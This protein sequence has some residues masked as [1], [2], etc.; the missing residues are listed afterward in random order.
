[1]SCIEQLLGRDSH[2]LCLWY[3]AY[4]ATQ[5]DMARSQ[6]QNIGNARI[7]ASIDFNSEK[8][9]PIS[10]DIGSGNSTLYT[11]HGCIHDRLD[12]Y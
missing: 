4:P 9:F 1:M 6:P 7:D 11:F 2:Y 8:L 12:L 10:R 3:S 5:S